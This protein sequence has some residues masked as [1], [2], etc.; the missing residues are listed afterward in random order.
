MIIIICDIPGNFSAILT[1]QAQHDNHAAYM[2]QIYFYSFT[3]LKIELQL[4]FLHTQSTAFGTAYTEPH[5]IAIKNK[6]SS[7]QEVRMRLLDHNP[8]GCWS[9]QPIHSSSCYTANIHIV[10]QSHPN[11]IYLLLNVGSAQ[12]SPPVVMMK[13]LLADVVYNYRL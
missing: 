9:V 1:G 6:L 13:R 3:C 5:M 7:T 10:V 4:K 2:Y 8:I 11:P 12:A